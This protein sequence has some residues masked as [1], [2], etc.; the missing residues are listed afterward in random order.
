MAEQTGIV[1]VSDEELFIA[2]MQRFS[3]Q[4]HHVHHAASPTDASGYCANSPGLMVVSVDQPSTELEQLLS[5]CALHDVRVLGLYRQAEAPDQPVDLLA[6]ADDREQVYQAAV[7]LLNERRS[8]PRVRLRLPVEVEGAG[9]GYS[10]TVSAVSMFVETEAM[11]E[12]GAR[13]AIQIL[14]GAGVSGD[15]TVVRSGLGDSGNAGMVLAVSGE[16]VSVFLRDQV[17]DA[18]KAYYEQMQAQ[19]LQALAHPQVQAQPPQD[20][21]PEP[22]YQELNGSGFPDDADAYDDAYDEPAT[23]VQEFAPVASGEQVHALQARLE[24]QQNIIERVVLRLRQLDKARESAAAAGSPQAEQVV[25]LEQQLEHLRQAQIDQ[26][27]VVKHHEAQVVAL[28]RGLEQVAEIA[29]SAKPSIEETGGS[30]QQAQEALQGQLDEL[31]HHIAAGGAGGADRGVVAEVQQQIATIGGRIESMEHEREPL[32][33]GLFETGASVAELER[34]VEALAQDDT[35][36]RLSDLRETVDAG[37]HDLTERVNQ[38][39]YQLEQAQEKTALDLEQRFEHQRVS[40][41][42]TFEEAGERVAELTQRVDQFAEESVSRGAVAE[43]EEQLVSRLT[44]AEALAGAAATPEEV[45]SSAEA[46]TQQLEQLRDSVEQAQTK[47]LEAQQEA[48]QKLDQR[49]QA[50]Q[51]VAEDLEQRLQTELEELEQR[52]QDGQS[53]LQVGLEGASQRLTELSGRIDELAGNTVAELQEQQRAAEKRLSKVEGVASDAATQDALESSGEALL[54]R[55]E[56]LAQRVDQA[57]GTLRQVTQDLEQAQE[58]AQLQEQAQ[59]DA[60]QEVEKRLQGRLAELQKRLDELGSATP[61]EKVLDER[62]Q[63]LT[64]RIEALIDSRLQESA[65]ESAAS[66][67]KTV[68]QETATALESFEE[69]RTEVLDM[70]EEMIQ[71]LGEAQT[72][73]DE[74]A[75]VLSRVVHRLDRM[76]KD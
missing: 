61:N 49:A 69:I 53:P 66:V 37:H 17:R 54:H 59:G 3:P 5:N 40:L 12:S 72:Q 11:L 56:Q 68:S 44:E 29:S 47:V 6:P 31:R 23:N 57:E 4:T 36:D 19:A 34:R 58:K 35:A 62:E 67:K 60:A 38:L 76:Q 13:V 39:A 28:G 71:Q 65:K 43:L 16:E 48:T 8:H 1:V 15:A 7:E 2:F 30:Q 24:R 32:Q 70:L 46:L 64:R 45:Q 74:Q 10:S 27:K 55:T 14:H 63:A 22:N 41:Q 20:L 9:K 26:D 33:A 73:L 25:G 18:L 21:Q 42:T 75:K 50:Q 52:M 51:Q